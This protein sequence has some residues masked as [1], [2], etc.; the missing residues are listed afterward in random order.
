MKKGIWFVI[1]TLL[2]TAAVIVVPAVQSSLT[3]H[4][5]SGETEVEK[6]K[7]KIVQE[8]DDSSS[9]QKDDRQNL[10]DDHVTY[11]VLLQEP[12]LV[13]TLLSSGTKYTSVRELI[14]SAQGKSRADAVK[15]SQAVAKASITKLVPQAD[16][17]GSRSY[18]ALLNGITVKAPES[19]REKLEKI[20]GT[21]AVYRIEDE[22]Y[23]FDEESSMPDLEESADDGDRPSGEVSA[24]DGDRPSGEISGGEADSMTEEENGGDEKTEPLYPNGQKLSEAYRRQTDTDGETAQRFQGEGELIAVLDSEFDVQDEAFSRLPENPVLS[25]ES[26]RSVSEHLKLNIK[27]ELRGEECFVSAKI[28]FAYDYGE[29][30]GEPYDYSLLH[31]TKTASIAAGSYGQENGNGYQGMAPQAQLALMKIASGRNEAGRIVVQT[32]AMLAA[33]D[34]AVKLGADVISLSAGSYELPAERELYR[35]VFAMLRQ[36]GISVVLSAGNGGSEARPAGDSFYAADNT[37]T[38]MGEVVAAGSVQGSYEVKHFITLQNKKIYYRNLTHQALA[39]NIQYMQAVGSILN[40][41]FEQEQFNEYYYLEEFT[42]K[43]VLHESDISG[44]TVILNVEDKLPPERFWKELSEKGAVAA[45]LTSL[46]EQPL[47]GT[48]PELPVIV[49]EGK[50]NSLLA[51]YPSGTFEIDT[52][53]DIKE[54]KTRTVSQFSS[55]CGSE[56]QKIGARLLTVGEDVYTGVSHTADK[57]LTG[58]SACAPGI[59]GAL[60]SVRQYLTET[61]SSL[62]GEELMRTAQALLL[63]AAAPMTAGNE[64]GQALYASPRVQGFGMLQTE[65]AL[66]A[67]AVVL[68]GDALQGVTLED[69]PTG[70]YTFSF[71]VRNLSDDSVTYRLSYAL[72]TD[73]V[74]DGVNTLRPRSLKN[75]AAVDFFVEDRPAE[76][77]TLS[78]GA[79]TE[80]KV[81]VQLQNHTVQE[82]KD[83][84]PNGCFVDGYVFLT[85]SKGSALNLPFTGFLGEQSAVSPFDNTV[86]DYQPSVTGLKGGLAAVAYQNGTYR[87]CSLVQQEDSILFSRDAVR[88]VQDDSSYGLS[89]ILPDFYTL[90]N[91]YDLTL[92]ISD[93]NG[94]QL[95][96]ENVGDVSCYRESY[97]R[98]FEKLTDGNKRLREFFQKLTPGK[99][100]YE[101]KA[102]AMQWDGSLSGPYVQSYMVTVDE[103]KPTELSAET[104]RRDGKTYLELKAADQSGI[105]YFV[106]YAT[107]YDKKTGQYHYIDS[108]DR[109]IEAGYLNSNAYVLLDSRQDEDGSYVF[110]YDITELQKELGT[111]VVSTETWS[112]DSSD[113]C[114]AYK[115]VDGAYHS[116]SVRTADTIVYGTAKFIFTDQNG[117]PAQGIT[118]RIGTQSAVTDE[119]GCAQLQKL[120][121]DYYNALFS[122]REEDYKL[123]QQSCLV[124]IGKDHTAF[125]AKLTVTALKEY[126]PPAQTGTDEQDTA[127]HRAGSAEGEKPDEPFYAVTFVTILLTVC[128]I[129]FL[130]RKNL[131]ARHRD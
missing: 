115:A 10:K 103:E 114:I 28:P 130:F 102:S 54:R 20:S 111:L 94:K 37:L 74:K 81:T 107:A 29:D 14:L 4:R 42:D 117:N 108:L 21:V 125:E 85:P 53:D 1:L 82:L 104:Y 71:A 56:H 30:D 105:Q 110:R 19:T 126:V 64:D 96:S 92:S 45:A 124:S 99:Y 12:S 25:K 90:R 91:T 109:M 95:F 22:W 68:H 121:P 66:Q 55:Y 116:S 5:Q 36:A 59:A 75:G 131:K 118:V 65:K 32:D 98:P 123:P 44:K 48:L 62:Y 112:S 51:Q 119:N 88:T 58:T 128:I 39:D 100:K 33:L 77:L 106:L 41:E 34:D 40:S 120:E 80:V 8:S 84:F 31:G 23:F 83:S 13:E 49:T 89:F 11:L 97:R 52:T 101:V 16:F 69:S 129:S 26:V 6:S 3:E 43:T 67:Q 57:L 70:E 60:A 35:L 122:C 50:W 27:E 61:D 127:E 24:D 87:Y 113:K 72:Q 38:A 2:L 17:S 63:S 46:P 15:K 73:S 76:N 7:N 79:V 18:S 86:Y 93:Q 78:A 9:V 47:P